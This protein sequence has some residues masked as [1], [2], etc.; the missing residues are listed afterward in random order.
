MRAILFAALAGCA[1]GAGDPGPRV[2]RV[3]VTDWVDRFDDAGVRCYLY[4]GESIS[5]VVPPKPPDEGFCPKS[6]CDVFLDYHDDG[7]PQGHW[8]H[9]PGGAR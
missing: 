7:T 5:C 8:E 4:A 2:E 3:R 1:V 9:V 6:K